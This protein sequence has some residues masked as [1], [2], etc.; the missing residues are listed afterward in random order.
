MARL[1]LGV[2]LGT[3]L[4]MGLVI[5]SSFWFSSLCATGCH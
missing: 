4:T 3:V 5:A 1:A 2:L